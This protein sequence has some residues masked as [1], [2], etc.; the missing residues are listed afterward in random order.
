MCSPAEGP[1]MVSLRRCSI[2]DLSSE[3]ELINPIEEVGKVV[4]REKASI[5]SS[6]E[7]QMQEFFGGKRPEVITI[8]VKTF[9]SWADKH[10]WHTIKLKK[11]SAA[12]AHRVLWANDALRISSLRQ[13]STG[14]FWAERELAFKVLLWLLFWRMAWRRQG[15]ADTM[16]MQMAQ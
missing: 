4:I 8:L 6:G 10:M 3:W 9:A 14:W 15:N 12:R 5:P 13:Q 11:Q 7:Q 2:W 1:G 16:A